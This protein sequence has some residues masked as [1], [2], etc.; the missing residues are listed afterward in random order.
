MLTIQGRGRG[1]AGRDMESGAGEELVGFGTD[2][3]LSLEDLPIDWMW[4]ED[5]GH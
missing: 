3:K 5:C 2:L 4:R 1:R